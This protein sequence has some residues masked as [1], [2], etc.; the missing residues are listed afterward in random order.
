MRCTTLIIPK[1]EGTSDTVGM[2]HEEELIGYCCSADGGNLMQLG[3]IH[4]HPS[5]SCFMSS[6][7]IHTHCGYQTMLPEAVAVVVA[8]R[9]PRKP[10][11]GVFRLTEPEGLQLIQRCELRG[12]HPH[13]L[14]DP[15]IYKNHHAVLWED[16]AF[17]V[18][19]LR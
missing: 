17:A 14:P 6:V 3:W 7:D 5:Q 13:P 19:D 15:Q 16:S 12:F 11:V 8:L 18:V 2:T 9:N 4:T 10:Q 1:Q